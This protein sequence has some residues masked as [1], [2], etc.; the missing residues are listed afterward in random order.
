MKNFSYVI[1]DPEG[2][3]ARPAGLL[4]KACAAYKSKI[5]IEKDGKSV[6]A[7]RLFGIMGLGVKQN[8]EVIVAAEGEDED[9]AIEA[10]EAFFKEN[11]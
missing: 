7:K 5:T 4:V 11:L 6:D 1:T 8:N 9:V 10:L 3:H 2:L